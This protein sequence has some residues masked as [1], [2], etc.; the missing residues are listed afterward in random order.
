MVR[1]LRG[2]QLRP[3]ITLVLA[4][5]IGYKVASQS[6]PPFEIDDQ[7]KANDF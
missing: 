5:L 2:D 7:S 1:N 3:F 6:M 4:L